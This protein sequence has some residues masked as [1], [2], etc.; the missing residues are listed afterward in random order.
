MFSKSLSILSLLSVM[1]FNSDSVEYSRRASRGH[2]AYHVDLPP[3]QM[4]VPHLWPLF[5]STQ[6]QAGVADSTDYHWVWFLL[7]H[8]KVCVQEY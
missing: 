5:K 8:T 2:K 3:A 6:S 7:F 4:K 1:P